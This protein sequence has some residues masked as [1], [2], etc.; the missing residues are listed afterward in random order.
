LSEFA[1]SAPGNDQWKKMKGGRDGAITSLKTMEMVEREQIFKVFV[2]A[3][4]KVSGK[5]QRLGNSGLSVVR[6]HLP[7]PVV[8][9]FPHSLAILFN[10]HRVEPLVILNRWSYL[11]SG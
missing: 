9:V 5:K 8:S 2:Q 7:S 3:N 1:V 4:W 11:T 6:R 10:L